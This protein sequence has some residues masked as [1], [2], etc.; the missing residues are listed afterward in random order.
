MEKRSDYWSTYYQCPEPGCGYRARYHAP[1]KCWLV[2]DDRTRKA[3]MRAHLH[4]DNLWRGD[5]AVMGRQQAY[6]ALARYMNLQFKQ[7]HIGLF[8]FTQC[9]M[10][11]EFSKKTIEGIQQSKKESSN[12]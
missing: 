4:F 5:S 7:T 1:T 6:K 10:V 3:R 8:D 11:V 9:G 12:A 2:S